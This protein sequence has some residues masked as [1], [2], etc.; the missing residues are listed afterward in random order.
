MARRLLGMKF[1]RSVLA[2]ILLSCLPQPPAMAAD[3]SGTPV[4]RTRSASDADVLAATRSYLELR[5]LLHEVRARFDLVGP[6]QIGEILIGEASSIGPDG[7]DAHLVDHTLRELLAE[8]TYYIVSLRYLI[9]SGGAAWPEGKPPAQ[10][11]N[12]ANVLLDALLT[13]LERSTNLGKDPWNVFHG[14]DRV[15]AWT[16]GYLDPREGGLDHFGDRP[17]LVEQALKNWRGGSQAPLN[18][19]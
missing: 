1:A 17:A 12:D 18:R 16:E 6:D 8:G 9:L 15:N 2:V 13:E 4:H 5:A 3:L 14:I 10:Y 11:E 7:P 19:R